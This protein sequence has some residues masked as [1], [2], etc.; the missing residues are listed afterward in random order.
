MSTVY[1]KILLIATLILLPLTLLGSSFEA[2]AGSLSAPDAQQPDQTTVTITASSAVQQ[3]TL[4][5][6]TREARQSAKPLP[7]PS[8][9]G[10]PAPEETE[11]AVTGQPSL[12]QGGQ[13]DLKAV[14]AARQQF[15]EEWAALQQDA[16]LQSDMG[17]EGTAGVY[18]SYLGNYF[19]QMWT[20]FPY[21]AV[22]KLYITGGGYC[23][24]SVISPNNI[25]VTAAH[26]VYNTD[27]NTWLGGWTFVPADRAG[28][29]PFGTFPWSSA[30]VLT[31]WVNASNSLAG[32]PYDVAVINLGNNSSGYPVT[33]YTGWLGRSWNYGYVQ[34]MHSIGYPSNLTNGTLYTYICSAESFQQG[35]DILGKGCNMMHGSSGGPWIRVFTPFTSGAR[36]Y[37]NSVVSGGLP[38]STWGNTYYGARFSDN[39]I[40]PLCSAAGC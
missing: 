17:I 4:K 14:R 16:T 5:A 29:A 8:V 15:P 6:W 11:P 39:N 2:R 36:N 19:S 30:T 38:G 26:C 28:S 32:R 27:T 24:A 31:N 23:S 18:T 37:V 10:N 1:R 13:P 25:I 33:A 22:G 40:V 35:A 7:F 9:Q 3:A 12:A 20:G 34:H 21:G